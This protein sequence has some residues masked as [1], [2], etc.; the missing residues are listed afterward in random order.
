VNLATVAVRNLWRNRLR[1][2]LTIVGVAVSIL[3]FVALRTLVYAWTSAAEYATKDRL[4]TRHKVTFVMPLPKRYIEDVRNTAGIKTATWANWF[5]AKD[6]KHEQEFFANFA[7]DKDTY[8]EV[9]DEMAVEP[10]GMQ[11]WKE[12]RQG[13]IVGDVLAKKMGW[14][15]GDKVTLESG[16]YP[17]NPDAP[18]NFTIE[19]IYTA[20]R[21]SVDRSSFYFHW[22]YLNDGLP[23]SRKDTIGWVI[24]RT[25]DPSRAAEF[26]KKLDVIFDAKDTQTLSQDEAAFNASFLA[27]FSA[28]LSV[29]DVISFALLVIM[30]LVLGNTIAMGVRERTF[31]YG[32]LRAVGFLPLHIRFFVLAEAALIGTLG[33]VIG[34]VMAYFFVDRGLGRFMEENMGNYFPYFSVPPKVWV[35]ALALAVGLA[36]LAAIWPARGATRISVTEALRRVV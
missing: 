13:A 11:K 3:T 10:S 25:V 20:T 18:W 28:V 24:S 12:N 6:P 23:A 33:G 16:I 15:V 21:K 27:G 32:T 19:G 17:A 2:I 7:V 30:M 1:T 4:V 31:E 34:M 22:E 9:Y 29:I 5:G 8:F 14:K 35:L 36:L 26:G